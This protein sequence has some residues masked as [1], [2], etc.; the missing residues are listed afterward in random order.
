MAYSK[1]Y[2]EVIAG[3]VR[4][5][6]QI[7]FFGKNEVAVGAPRVTSFVSMGGQ[8]QPTIVEEANEFVGKN[9]DLGGVTST[10]R[11]KSAYRPPAVQIS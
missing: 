1:A 6:E 2:Q 11:N 9:V 3:R 7:A 10:K 8:T 4:E 5:D